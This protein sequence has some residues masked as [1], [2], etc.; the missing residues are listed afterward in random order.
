LTSKE[1][2]KRKLRKRLERE[3][4]TKGCQGEKAQVI[5]VKAEAKY[6]PVSSRRKEKGKRAKK[7]RRI[8]VQGIFGGG[9]G[10]EALDSRA[11]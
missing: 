2:K 5:H 3:K 10:N 11:P 6:L 9:K 8:N 7:K 1:E 4:K